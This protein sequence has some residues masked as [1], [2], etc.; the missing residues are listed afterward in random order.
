M[1]RLS[2]LAVAVLTALSVG[3][4]ASPI[5]VNAEFDSDLSGWQLSGQGTWSVTWLALDHGLSGV[6]Q[7][8]VTG[9]PGDAWI[10]QQTLRDI[11]PGEILEVRVWHDNIGSS[12]G[13]SLCVGART[14]WDFGK[15]EGVEVG[16]WVADSLIPAGTQINL[17]TSA[18]P[19]DGPPPHTA[20]WDYIRV[21]PEPSSL[22]A[23]L[24]GLAGLGGLV[25]RR[26]R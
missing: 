18:W 16:R 17:S 23:L 7:A 10:K 22:T 6:A 24:A 15:F 13:G 1:V 9:A 14:V 3:A 19:W 5:V 8:Q 4:A 2:W 25:R 20:S 12:G 26:R 21:V 11:L